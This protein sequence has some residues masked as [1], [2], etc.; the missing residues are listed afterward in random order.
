MSSMGRS[1]PSQK[2]LFAAVGLGMLMLPDGA[3][4]QSETSSASEGLGSLHATGPAY[5]GA[6]RQLQT[7]GEAQKPAA[8]A[9]A[10]PPY[11]LPFQLRGVAAATTLRLDTSVA[12]YDAAGGGTSTTLATFVSGSYKILPELGAFFRAGIVHNSPGDAARGAGMFM[13]PALGAVYAMKLSDF[14]LAFV[15]GATLPLGQGGGDTPDPKLKALRNLGMLSR[16]GMDNAMFGVNDLGVFPGVDFAWVKHGLTVQAEATVIFAIRA[17]GE[18]DQPDT[19]KVNLT[20]GLH[21]GYFLT[22]WLSLGTELRL[23][24][25]LEEPKAIETSPARDTLLGT[26]SF[27]IGPRF[28]YKAGDVWIRP[29]IVYA[30]GLDDPMSA[31]GYD[32]VQ[33]DIP[34]IF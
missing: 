1:R 13:N 20:A 11:S 18:V 32:V 24:R 19:L 23:Q 5:E 12:T 21:A 17:R 22:D 9:G 27:A 33:L 8:P 34:M 25:W 7:P 4:A 10:A 15:A 2:H 6:E 14:R 16:S 26:T 30:R 29:A 28:H 31:A 3:M